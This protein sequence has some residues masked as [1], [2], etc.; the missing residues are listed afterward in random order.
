L[1]QFMM[2]ILRN[3]KISNDRLHTARQLSQFALGPEIIIDSFMRDKVNWTSVHKYLNC[4]RKEQIFESLEVV[5]GLF[6]K[7]MQQVREEVLQLQWVAPD[8]FEGK[9]IEELFTE[10]R[11]QRCIKNVCRTFKL[12]YPMK[13]RCC[14]L[15][16]ILDQELEAYQRGEVEEEDFLYSFNTICEGNDDVEKEA[17]KYVMKTAESLGQYLEETRHPTYVRGGHRLSKKPVCQQPYNQALHQLG[18]ECG[19]T[20]LIEGEK[21]VKVLSAELKASSHIT[22]LAH[23]PPKLIREVDEIDLLTVRTRKSVFAVL[24]KVFPK[25]CRQLEQRCGTL[26]RNK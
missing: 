7:P 10:E 2:M 4:W 20:R 22:V 9:A 6:D 1:H 16:V 17:L 25:Q 11:Y 15:L 18:R 14:L 21:D 3:G 24:P 8:Y 5:L 26:W 12:E 23:A 13:F 19:E